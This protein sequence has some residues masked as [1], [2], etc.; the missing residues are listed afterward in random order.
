MIYLAL[1]VLHMLAAAA[2]LGGLA[3]QSWALR[4][5]AVVDGNP[6]LVRDRVAFLRRCV[7]WIWGCIVVV[8]GTGF[9][10]LSLTGGFTI[11]GTP[12]LLMMTLGVIM[13]ALFKF[14]C[15]A[16]LKHLVRGMEE[17]RPGVVT[18]ALGTI[19]KLAVTNFV[20]GVFAAIVALIR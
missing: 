6:G 12:V 11:A 14:S 4:P 1:I 8:L 18:Y 19:H 15:L 3:H 13:T 2:W 16:P 20:L 17:N 9:V 7:P 10:L 5:S